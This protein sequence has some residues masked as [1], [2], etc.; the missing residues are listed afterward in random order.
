MVV[1]HGRP[2]RRRPAP[3]AGGGSTVTPSLMVVKAQTT[4]G[5]A[6]SLSLKAAMARPFSVW[7]APGSTSPRCKVLSATITPRADSLGSTAS[8]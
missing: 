1:E 8:K 7:R 4:R 5:S 6:A 3:P 2:V